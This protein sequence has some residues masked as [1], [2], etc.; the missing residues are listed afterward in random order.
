MTS[1]GPIGMTPTPWTDDPNVRF[2]FGISDD[3]LAY[4]RAPNGYAICCFPNT[5]D[6]ETQN[7]NAAYI[8]LAVNS[9]ARLVELL[10]LA[11]ETPGMVKGRVMSQAFLA[12]LRA[13]NPE[14][15]G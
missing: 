5:F 13:A 4:V 14:K 15:A 6:Q 7:A 11:M 8:V 12:E 9:H 3:A 1:K 10:R 2:S